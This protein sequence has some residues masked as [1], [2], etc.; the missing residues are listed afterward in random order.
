MFEYQ[1]WAAT[2]AAWAATLSF[3]TPLVNNT[4]LLSFERKT[5]LGHSSVSEKTDFKM[6]QNVRILT[7]MRAFY[8]KCI[9]IL[10]FQ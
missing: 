9:K 5:L 3:L 1:L 7:K 4:C 2:F 6:H 10:D 8:S